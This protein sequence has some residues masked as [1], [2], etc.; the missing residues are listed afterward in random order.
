MKICGSSSD[1]TLIIDI[2][3]KKALG[4]DGDDHFILRNDGNVR[5][6]GGDGFDLFEFQLLVGQTFT[7]SEVTDEKTVIKIFDGGEQVQKIVLID[8]EQTDWFMVG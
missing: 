5:V 3:V 1:D 7:T 6:D 4:R 8:I 2:G